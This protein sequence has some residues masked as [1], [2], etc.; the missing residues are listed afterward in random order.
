[1]LLQARQERA[2]PEV[3]IIAAGLSVP[4]PRER[5]EDAK[6]A[7]AAAH[8]AFAVADSDFLSLLKIWRAMPEIVPAGTRCAVL[9]RRITFRNRGCENGATCI[10]NSRTRC[11]MS[12]PHAG[13][14][15][16]PPGSDEAIHRS[17]LA[18]TARADRPAQGTQPLPGVG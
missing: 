3:L 8:R 18:G 14:A 9:R 13:N 11:R 6:E 1:M 17:I 5:P 10:G 2:L 7:A 16:H 4:D 12:A 15:P